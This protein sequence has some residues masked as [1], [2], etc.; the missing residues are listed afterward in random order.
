M[1]P[2]D[3]TPI[4]TVPDHIEAAVVRYIDAVNAGSL[5]ELRDVIAEDITI[6]NPATELH[7]ADAV[8]D[9]YRDVV[10]AGKA[11]FD[12][13]GVAV[14]GDQVVARIHVR[15]PFVPDT[16]VLRAIDVYDL[17]DTG[18]IVTLEGHHR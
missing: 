5:K 8:C 2:S 18:R 1:S 11:T 15:S 17:D 13:Q 3:D 12:L 16:I 6:W 9:Y 4:G 7:G 14:M 10:F